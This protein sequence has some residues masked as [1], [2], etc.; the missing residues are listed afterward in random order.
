MRSG[1]FIRRPSVAWCVDMAGCVTRIPIVEFYTMLIEQKREL[2]PNSGHPAAPARQS[3][4][5]SKNVTIHDNG[6]C[7]LHACAGC[8]KTAL[9]MLLCSRCHAVFYC[10]K[11]CQRAHWKEHKPKC[12]AA[13]AVKGVAEIPIL[14]PHE[15]MTGLPGIM[16]SLRM[17]GKEMKRDGDLIPLVRVMSTSDERRAVIT[18]GDIKSAVDVDVLHTAYPG[19]EHTLRVEDERLPSHMARLVVLIHFRGKAVASRIR[20]ALK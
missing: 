20:I 6:V 5:G 19:L 15:W 13:N 1:T 9:R 16:E 2:T 3:V 7:M 18:Y 14:S 4:A 10:N 17:A 12:N 8:G 11:G